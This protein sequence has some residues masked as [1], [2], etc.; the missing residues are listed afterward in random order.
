MRQTT[1]VEPDPVDCAHET[2]ARTCGLMGKAPLAP[3]QVA[4]GFAALNGGLA[5]WTPG[6]R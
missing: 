5:D 4:G 6:C 3:G 2:A 1:S